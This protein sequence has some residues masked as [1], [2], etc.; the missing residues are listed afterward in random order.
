MH[1]FN[2]LRLQNSDTVRTIALGHASYL[3]ILHYSAFVTRTLL[4]L[5][6]FIVFFVD[7]MCGIYSPCMGTPFHP[8]Y[9]IIHV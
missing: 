1:G 9:S 5:S 3:S 6:S 8:V 4:V 2:W 7:I